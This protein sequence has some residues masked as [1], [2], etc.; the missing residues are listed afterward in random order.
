[1][2][3]TNRTKRTWRPLAGALEKN[4]VSIQIIITNNKKITYKKTI[5]KLLLIF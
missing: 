5:E 2:M 3:E 1:M 4:V